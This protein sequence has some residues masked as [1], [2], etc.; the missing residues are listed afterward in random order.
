MWERGRKLKNS[1]GSQAGD[2]LASST[3]PWRST[4]NLTEEANAHN[5]RNTL[6]EQHVHWQGQDRYAW[7]PPKG[8]LRKEQLNDMSKQLVTKFMLQLHKLPTSPERNCGKI[9]GTL[10]HQAEQTWT[11]HRVTL[12]DEMNSVA[13]DAL[14]NLR[15][16]LLE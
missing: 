2:G 13:G 9:R 5:Y 14:E 1:Y 10:E 16:T 7:N 12:L 6:A 11:S 4:R 8:S 15:R 3:P